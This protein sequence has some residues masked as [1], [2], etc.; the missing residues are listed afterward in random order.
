M[1]DALPPFDPKSWPAAKTSL[2]AVDALVPYARN[3]RRHSEAQIEQVAA[4]IR[5]WGWTSPVLIDEAGGIIAGH[6]RIL[7]AKKLGIPKVPV[8]IAKGWSEAQKRAYVL[9]DNK[10]SL[11]ATWDEELLVGELG[12]LRG[13]DEVDLALIGFSEKELAKLLPGEPAA[14]PQLDSLYQ[15]LIECATEAEQLDVL[16]KLQG[17]G[18]KGRALIA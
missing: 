12:D 5:E 17:L 6:G 8:M 10:L 15:V 18:I 16:T 14:A 9:A 13:L 11:N 7:A 3:A 4:A 1:P 2:R